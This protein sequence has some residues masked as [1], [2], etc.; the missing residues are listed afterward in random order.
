MAVIRKVLL[1]GFAAVV[2]GATAQADIAVI[3]SAKN[4]ARAMSAEEISQIYLGKSNALKPLDNAQKVRGQF[5]SKVTGKDESQ[6]KAIW[7]KLIFTGK[8]M[9]PKALASDA[10]VLKA[11]AANANTIGYVEKSAVDSSVKVVFEAR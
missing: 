3:V 5:Y 2:F 4:S 11:V 1:A 7:S 10:E 6:I 8:G 9:P